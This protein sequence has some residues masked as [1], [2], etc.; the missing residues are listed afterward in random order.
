M[1]FAQCPFFMNFPFPPFPRTF[2]LNS[3]TLEPRR[4]ETQYGIVTLSMA[5]LCYQ[6]T[7]FSIRLLSTF[8]DTFRHFPTYSDIFRQSVDVAICWGDSWGKTLRWKKL[9]NAY[10]L[11]LIIPNNPSQYSFLE[12]FFFGLQIVRFRVHPVQYSSPS[13]YC[14]TTKHT[15][16]SRIYPGLI[17][18]RKHFFGGL[19]IRGACIRGGLIF[20]GNFVLVSEFQDFIILCYISLLQSKKVFLWIRIIFILL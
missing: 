10:K 7:S 12:Q 17:N 11:C 18:L 20:E 5:Q 3:F 8:S 16:K 2:S 19:Y 14:I 4:E 6:E 13:D 1:H 15:V 9:K